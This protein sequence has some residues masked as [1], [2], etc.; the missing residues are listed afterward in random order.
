MAPLHP[1]FV[2]FP[3]AL[4]VFSFLTDLLGRL[5]KKPSLRA[6]GAWCLVGVL[7]FAAITAATGYYDIRRTKSVLGDTFRYV[8]VHMDVGWILVG[9]VVVLRAVRLSVDSGRGVI[10]R[11]PY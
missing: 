1:A 6:T 8:D 7:L 11:S 3:I 5:F 9:A 10:P 4:M 2:H